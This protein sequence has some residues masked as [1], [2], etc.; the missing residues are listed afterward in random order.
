[1]ARKQ[2][3]EGVKV[4]QEG[5]PYDWDNMLEEYF[6]EYWSPLYNDEQALAVAQLMSDVGRAMKMEYGRESTTYNTAPFT[7]LTDYFNYDPDL[8]QMI[9]RNMVSLAQWTEIIKKDI[10]ENR[11]VYYY[12]N[13]NAGGHM[14]VCDGYDSNDLFHIN[15]GWGGYC[16]GFFDITVLNPNSN[17]G[18]GASV[19]AD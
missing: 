6:D 18:T 1:M 17:D 3:W 13:S 7:A 15:W 19:T 2:E 4:G 5:H 8:I 14:F 9:F 16:D 11:P 10:N 12:G